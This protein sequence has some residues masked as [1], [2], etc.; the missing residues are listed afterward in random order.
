MKC[1]S[2]EFS[3]F[4]I[5]SSL[6]F[7]FFILHSLLFIHLSYSI[8][9]ALYSS[10]RNPERESVSSSLDNIFWQ[11]EIIMVSLVLQDNFFSFSYSVDISFA[12]LLCFYQTS[13]LLLCSSIFHLSHTFSN[14]IFFTCQSVY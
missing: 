11:S 12:R 2:C 8:T 5:L 9:D 7:Y 6:F 13:L 14:D 3:L 1:F 4:L 10:V